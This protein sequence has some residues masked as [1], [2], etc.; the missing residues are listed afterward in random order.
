MLELIST[1]PLAVV[2]LS[3]LNPN[4]MYEMAIRH[5]TGKAVA[6]VAIA[7]TQL[8]FDV[9][10]LRTV[11]FDL[12]DPDDL[13]R[14]RVDL[15][16]QL[17]AFLRQPNHSWSMVPGLDFIAARLNEEQTRDLV[18]LHQASSGFRIYGVID[19]TVTAVGENPEAFDAENF[20][21]EIRN[22]LAESRRLCAAFTSARLGNLFHVYEEHYSEAELRATVE[23]GQRILLDAHLD[24]GTKRKRLLAY[25]HDAQLALHARIER[26]LRNEDAGK[27]SSGI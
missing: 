18:Q 27:G 9:G 19:E 17:A 2:D 12:G 20:F 7:G 25:L 4:V 6:Q 14:A 22:A 26:L 21:L 1:A 24:S 13:T 11:V 16:E 15:Q 10:A 23:G 3:G 8:P 5:A